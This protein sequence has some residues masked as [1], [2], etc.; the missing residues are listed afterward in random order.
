MLFSKVGALNEN[1]LFS[2]EKE[3]PLN[4]DDEQRAELIQRVRDHPML[5]KTTLEGYRKETDKRVIWVNI[6]EAMKLKASGEHTN[7]FI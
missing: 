6:V 3:P 2:K 4:L 1:E 5:W 7:S